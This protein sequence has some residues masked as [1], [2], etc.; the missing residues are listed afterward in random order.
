VGVVEYNHKDED[1]KSKRAKLEVDFV[2]NKG[3]K[4]CYIQSAFAI[5]GE[6]KRLQEINS[7]RRINDS[8]KK[9]VVV[10]DHIIPWYDENGIY[11]IGVEDFVINYIDELSKVM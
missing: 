8:Y 6:E 3:N 7:L 4:R 11:Y 5:S 9:I 1:G 10:R 2:A